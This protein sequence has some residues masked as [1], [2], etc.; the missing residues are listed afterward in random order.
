MG[1]IPWMPQNY[2]IS[3]ALSTI[4]GLC[5]YYDEGMM[6]EVTST[7]PASGPAWL[8]LIDSLCWA[9]AG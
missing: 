4:S 2:A 5:C 8:I 6:G 1:S 9:M 7:K 3:V